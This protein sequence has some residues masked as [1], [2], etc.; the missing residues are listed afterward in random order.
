MN[1]SGAPVDHAAAMRLSGVLEDALQLLRDLVPADALR[2]GAGP[3]RET[4]LQ[5]C[6][7]M[8]HQA[9]ATEREPVR[10]L[11]HFACTGGSLIGKCV[12]AMPNVQFVSEVDPLSTMRWT[13]GQP[14]FAPTDTFLQMRQSTRGADDGLLL[15][16]F[17]D[18]V[19][20]IHLDAQTR[21]QRLVLRDHAHGHFCVGS[22]VPERPT[23]REM[24]PTDIGVL[25]VLTVRHPV[26]SYASLAANGWICHEPATLDEYCRRYA[27]FLDRYADV[28][29]V[30]YEDFVDDPRAEMRRICD[31]LRLPY[32]SDFL[33]FYD[34]IRLTGESG[35]Q[36]SRI[37]TR[38]PRPLPEALQA[39]LET[40]RALA[41]L[42]R[43][44]GYG[45]AVRS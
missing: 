36:G 11:H 33:D 21:G 17:A 39:E 7:A 12:A 16:M 14:Q 10:T 5:Q 18:N 22:Q 25:S 4:L 29:V 38:P 15:R 43:R 6:L 35:R 24:L 44:L 1:D 32:S 19:R 26:D 31:L 45:R 34:V 40:S 3:A 2:P 27:L 41:P 8:C 30:R 23:L 37:E 13:P 20:H 9:A 28:A 42:S